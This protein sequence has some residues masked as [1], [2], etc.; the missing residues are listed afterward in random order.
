MNLWTSLIVEPSASK[1]VLREGKF[2]PRA[3][4]AYT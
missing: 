4:K 3:L 2:R 1:V